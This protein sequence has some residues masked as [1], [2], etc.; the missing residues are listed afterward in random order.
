MACGCRELEEQYGNGDCKCVHYKTRLPP[1]KCEKESTS[2][3]SPGPVA[4]HEVLIRTI[5]TTSMWMSATIVKPSY[6]RTDPK[7]RGL[8]V[9]RQGLIAVDELRATQT[10]D[11]KNRH[12]YLRYASTTFADIKDLGS[13]HPRPV[14]LRIRHRSAERSLTRR[15][16]PRGLFPAT[17]RPPGDGGCALPSVR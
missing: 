13:Q 15:H 5:L 2:E 16:L 12:G 11:P 4:A 8:S 14:L 9:N 17:F 3:H 6:F 10:S 7:A 1:C